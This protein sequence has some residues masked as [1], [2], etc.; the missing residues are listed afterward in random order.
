MFLVGCFGQPA[1]LTLLVVEKAHIRFLWDCL[2]AVLTLGSV[3]LLASLGQT[4]RVAI[5][6]YAAGLFVSY[7]ALYAL[8]AVVLRRRTEALESAQSSFIAGREEY[9]NVH[10]TE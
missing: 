7:V 4:D 2:R 10:E 8:T 3:S 1:A 6:G 5:A 9:R